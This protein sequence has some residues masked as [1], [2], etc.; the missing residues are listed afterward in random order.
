GELVVG[1]H[2]AVAGG[3]VGVVVAVGGGDL[4]LLPGGVPQPR[5]AGAAVGGQPERVDHGGVAFVE[6]VLGQVEGPGAGR[7][8][9]VLGPVEQQHGHLVVGVVV[10]D[11]G[12]GSADALYHAEHG[13][14][15]GGPGQVAGVGEELD[16]GHRAEPEAVPGPPGV[17]LVVHVGHVAAA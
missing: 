10:L 7:V 15:V 2:E 6:V 14:V 5:V 4:G 8:V 12:Q 11:G 17:I 3:G 1:Q 9:V 13:D 16:H